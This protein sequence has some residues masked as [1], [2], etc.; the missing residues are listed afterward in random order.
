MLSIRG[1]W[2][3]LFIALCLMVSAHHG[4][5]GIAHAAHA[6]TSTG[7]SMHCVGDTCVGAVA[8]DSHDDARL[9]AACVAILALAA[10]AALGRGASRV[11]RVARRTISTGGWCVAV[12]RQRPP[13]HGPPRPIRPC[14]LLR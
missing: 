10:A 4:V 14:V 8:E 6:V 11:V 3:V 1:M 2:R 7:D 9:L 5:R 13:A 12:M